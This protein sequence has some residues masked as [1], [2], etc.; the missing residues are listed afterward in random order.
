MNMCRESGDKTPISFRRIDCRLYPILPPFYLLD[1]MDPEAILNM[2]TLLYK[3]SQNRD[4][5][6]YLVTLLS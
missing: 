6:K 2:I 4:K 1:R 3:L 5:L